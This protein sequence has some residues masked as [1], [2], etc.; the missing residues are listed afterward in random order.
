MSDTEPPH[1]KIGQAVL[2]D[3]GSHEAAD[4]LLER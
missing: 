1:F 3:E 2:V 4:Q